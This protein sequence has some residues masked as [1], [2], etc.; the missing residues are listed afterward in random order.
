MTEEGKSRNATIRRFWRKLTAEGLTG[1]D[2]QLAVREAAGA[3]LGEEIDSSYYHGAIKRSDQLGNPNI[4]ELNK[5]QRKPQLR[6]ELRKLC[7]RWRREARK[8]RSTP[9]GGITAANL[10]DCSEDVLSLL[11]ATNKKRVKVA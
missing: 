10:D 1:K 8:Y 5:S 3:A 6:K 11:R 2:L 4:D 9:G 7:L